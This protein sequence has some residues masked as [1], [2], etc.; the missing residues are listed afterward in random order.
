MAAWSRSI[1]HDD[2]DLTLAARD[3]G[4][5][6]DSP[7]SARMFRTDFDETPGLQF[8]GKSAGLFA[9]LAGTRRGISHHA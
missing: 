7:I 8:A 3:H 1:Q 2:F 9:R 4:I 6:G 5:A